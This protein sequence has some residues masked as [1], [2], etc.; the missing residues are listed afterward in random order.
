MD[1]AV[2]R[3]GTADER[4]RAAPPEW[5]PPV[6]ADERLAWE[7]PRPEMPGDVL[8]VEAAAAAGRPVF[9]AHR[10]SVDGLVARPPTRRQP[11]GARPRHRG[12]HRAG[13]AGTDARRRA[14]RATQRETRTRRSA[15]RVPRGGR[16]LRAD[17]ARAWL[18]GDTHVGSMTREVNRFF[19]RVGDRALQRRPAVADLSRPRALRPALLARQPDRLDAARRRRL[20]RSARRAR[21]HDRRRRGPADDARLRRAQP[22][23]AALRPARTDAGVVDPASVMSVRVALVGARQQLQNAHDLG[24]ARHRRLRRVPHPDQAALGRGGHRRGGVRRGGH[25]RHVLAGSPSVDLA[26]GLI[27]TTAS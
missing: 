26:L 6:Y 14:A 11:V 2:R 17:P 23:A 4:I 1:A 24:D 16:R 25:Q 12:H 7:G 20:A 9:F 10:R 18:L 3:G 13:D 19:A 5:R 21:R 22:A 27:I 8:R 15:R